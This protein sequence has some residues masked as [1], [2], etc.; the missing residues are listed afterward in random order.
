M[1]I[2]NNKQCGGQ[3]NE[4][5]EA[6][7]AL[8]SEN[9]STVHKE[10]K[11]FSSLSVLTVRE[12]LVSSLVCKLTVRFS[13]PIGYESESISHFKP[14]VRTAIKLSIAFILCARWSFKNSRTSPEYFFFSAKLPIANHIHVT[15]FISTKLLKKRV[16]TQPCSVKCVQLKRV[17]TRAQRERDWRRARSCVCCARGEKAS[18]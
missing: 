15:V 18:I 4:W 1:L 14:D 8:N 11:S 9:Q 7:P 10:L 5:K 12:T 16:A 17:D 13:E 6:L 2:L 3:Y